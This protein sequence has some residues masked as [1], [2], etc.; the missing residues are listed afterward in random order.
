MAFRLPQQCA[1]QC[2]PTDI[3]ASGHGRFGH[4]RLSQ[5]LPSRHN[6]IGCQLALPANWFPARL[7]RLHTRACPFGDQ[8]PLEFRKGRRDVQN[9]PPG[10]RCR[11]DAIVQR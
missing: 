4:A 7:S 11:V 6:L 8:V 5:E 3:Q 9:Q 2:G 1:V 10:W